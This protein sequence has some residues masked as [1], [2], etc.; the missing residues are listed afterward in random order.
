MVISSFVAIRYSIPRVSGE[1]VDQGN[2]GMLSYA[3][4]YV[5]YHAFS[6]SCISS[7][8]S[9]TSLFSLSQNKLSAV[10]TSSRYDTCLHKKLH[11]YH[12]EIKMSIDELT[13]IGEKSV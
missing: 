7:F 2:H 11:Q 10:P 4:S 3:C 6:H 8:W 1:R 12:V 13:R 9:P 5:V